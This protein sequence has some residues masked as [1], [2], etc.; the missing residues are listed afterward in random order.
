[1]DSD[2]LTDR[3]AG[4]TGSDTELT[5]DLSSRS[6]ACASVTGSLVADDLA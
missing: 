4:S 1:M 3:F 6:D 2:A 5:F